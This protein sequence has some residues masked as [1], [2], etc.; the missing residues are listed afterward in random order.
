MT[1]FSSYFA[2]RVA[3]TQAEIERLQHLR[4]EVYCREF[5]Y[6]R[7][8]DCPNEREA[9]A[10][11]GS[12]MHLYAEHRASGLLAGTVR[13]VCADALGDGLSLPLEKAYASHGM[14]IDMGSVPRSHLIE[15][16]RLAVA[17]R[18]RRRSGESLSPVGM[19]VLADPDAGA[20]AERGFPLLSLA[21]YLSVAALADVRGAH[22]AFGYAMMQ[23]RLV[24]LLNR[25][26]IQFRQAGPSIDYHG[27][28]AAYRITLDEVVEALDE[29]MHTLYGSL[30]ET[31]AADLPCFSEYPGS[32]CVPFPS[33]GGEH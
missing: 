4:W 12:A 22:D 9:D 6:E 16:S 24:R 8:E 17:A 23:P 20:T 10:F 21:L 15:I 28:R 33:M 5:H 13:I 32:I 7:E 1:D 2:L 29:N 30:V 18:F 11:D 26:G 3:R 31:I 27:E 25:F 19:D 14:S